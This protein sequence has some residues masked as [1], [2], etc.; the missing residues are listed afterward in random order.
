M[1]KEDLSQLTTANLQEKLKDERNALTK[2]RFTH[3]ISPVE[4]PMRIRFSKKNI[5]RMLTELRKRE[6]ENNKK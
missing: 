5:A 1:K 2:M 4:N 6:N 3:S